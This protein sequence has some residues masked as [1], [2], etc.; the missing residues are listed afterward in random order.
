MSNPGDVT[1]YVYRRLSDDEYKAFKGTPTQLRF[2]RNQLCL[3][4]HGL[5]GSR[6]MDARQRVRTW[7]NSNATDLYYIDHPENRSYFF[8]HFLSA[9]D[10]AACKLWWHGNNADKP[11]PGDDD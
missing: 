10:V 11:L 2:L 6:N 9:T 5:E 7:L 1:A 3:T 4:I 8:V